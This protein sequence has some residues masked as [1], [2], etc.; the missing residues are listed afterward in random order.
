MKKNIARNGP[1]LLSPLFKASAVARRTSDFPPAH[2]RASYSPPA[3]ANAPASREPSQRHV[4][5]CP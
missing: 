4:S 1:P 3:R 5:L 2:T